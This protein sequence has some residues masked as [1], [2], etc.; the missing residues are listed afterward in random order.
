MNYKVISLSL[1]GRFNKIFKSG[2]IVTE[3]HFRPGA[4]SELLEK[5][6]LEKEKMEVAT[7]IATNQTL[8]IVFVT[9][10]W[11]RHHVFKMF[12][13]SIHL[14]KEKSNIDIDVI[15]SGS[16]GELSKNLVLYEGFKYI[17]IP[18]EPLAQKVNAPVLLAKKIGA[19]NIICLGS[20]D[21][22]SIELFNIYIE[23]IK[24]GYDYIGVT[25]FYFYDLNSKKSS[26]W[27][28]YRENWRSGHTAGA[29]RVLSS[30]LLDKWGWKPWD[31]IHNKILDNSIQEKL[32]STSH[33]A[34]T[35]SL[36]EKNVLAVDIKSDINMTPFKLWDNT[37]FIENNIIEN[38]FP[39]ICVV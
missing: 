37:I 29:G 26:Y 11:K 20:D 21:L 17:E 5:G 25:D 19:T 1:G 12:A 3:N 36:K 2:D 35:F 28:G 27:G 9:A 7:L 14:I 34:K 4:I 18:N 8:K 13:K 32:K 16:E 6:F 22:I 33:T 30:K 10:I 24:Q 39:F 23:Y 31:N 38:K 15:V